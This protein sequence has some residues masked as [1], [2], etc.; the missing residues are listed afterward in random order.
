MVF[1]QKNLIVY[2]LLVKVHEIVGCDFN[3]F[4]Y[5]LLSMFDTNGN[6]VRL[7]IKTD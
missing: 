6:V 1:V 4:V 7:N 5:E 3:R 2:E